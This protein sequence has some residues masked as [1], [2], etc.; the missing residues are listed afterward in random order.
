MTHKNTNGVRSGEAQ[1]R[2]QTKGTGQTM[3]R[4]LQFPAPDAMPRARATASMPI[5]RAKWTIVELVRGGFPIALAARE[6]GLHPAEVRG[7]LPQDAV[8]AARLCQ[9]AEEYQ[10][11]LEIRCHESLRKMALD[12]QATLDAPPTAV[13]PAERLRAAS[14]LNR[15]VRLYEKDMGRVVPPTQTGRRAWRRQPETPDAA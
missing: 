6:V 2:E 10:A 13:R 9:A 3:G 11:E 12:L 5:A 4:L 7:W 8:F 14:L 15:I 1:G